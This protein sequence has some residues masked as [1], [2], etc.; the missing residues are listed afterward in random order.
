MLMSVDYLSRCDIDDDG[1][2]EQNYNEDWM[3]TVLRAGKMVYSQGCC[4]LTVNNLSSLLITGDKQDESNRLKRL[5][6][7]A[8]QAVEQKL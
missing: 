7:K 5:A 1:L 4:I 3:D 8:V 6:E 2:L